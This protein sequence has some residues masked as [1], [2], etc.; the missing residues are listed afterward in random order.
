MCYIKREGAVHTSDVEQ[1]DAIARQR[2]AGQRPFII[3]RIKTEI[4]FSRVFAFV[5]SAGRS[6]NVI[7]TSTPQQCQRCRYE[8]T[9]QYDWMEGAGYSDTGHYYSRQM[10]L[11]PIHSISTEAIGSF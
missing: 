9:V 7:G 6:V 4:Q 11:R 5:L 10:S 1:F 3:T 2:P 8:K